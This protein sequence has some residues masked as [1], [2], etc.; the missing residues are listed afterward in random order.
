MYSLSQIRWGLER[1]RDNPAYV[2]RECNRLFHRRL[3]G[4]DF[5]TD[6]TDVMGEEWDNLL[7]LDACR[8]DLFER[9]ATLPGRL[10]RRTSRGSHTF[11]FLVGNVGGRTLYDTVYVTASPQLHRWSDEID[12]RFHDVVEVW[13][14]DGWDE[15][16]GTVLPETVTDYARKAHERYP[17]KRLIVH[18]LQP[19]YP[20]IDADDTVNVGTVGSSEIDIW[21]VMMRGATSVSRAALWRAY[22]RNLEHALPAVEAL[23]TD[24]PGRTVVTSDHG[25]AF[26][27]RSFPLPIREWGHPRGIHTPELVNV[28][29]LVLENG[30]R[31]EVVWE[32]PTHEGS[33]GPSDGVRSRLAQLGYVE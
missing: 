33:T 24:L 30:R 6:G 9:R 5:N 29:W 19:H 10:E 31:K 11:E 7:L 18:Y 2:G 8:Y 1:S 26:G 21:G 20:F 12:A 17:N 22:R 27:E 13:R 4:R 14:G 3:N 25:N 15:E 23:L 28:P 16:H 32:E